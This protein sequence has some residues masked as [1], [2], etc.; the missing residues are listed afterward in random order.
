MK[1]VNSFHIASAEDV[2]GGKT[3]DIYFART[4]QILR[5]KKIDKHVV[6]EVR[7]KELPHAYPWAVFAGLEYALRMLERLNC[8]V[9]VRA[10][11]ERTVFGAGDVVF[12]IAGRYNGFCIYETPIL[13]F[14]CHASGI[15][16]AA[17]R[18][19][20]A[21]GNRALL[22]FGARRMHPSLAP[23]ID[24]N[25][26]AGGMDGVSVIASAEALGI[27]PSGTMPHALILVI[28]NTVEATRAFRTIIGPKVACVSLIDTFNDEKI[29]SLNVARALG[30]SLYAVR[31]DTPGSRRGDM[32]AI[33]KEVRWELD[34]NGFRHVKLYVSGGLDEEKILK[35]NPWADGYGVGTHIAS[36]PV[37]DFA[38]DI[39]AI[40]G[41]PVA[42]RG[43]E[44]GEKKLMRC[45]R[46]HRRITLPLRDPAPRCACGRVMR[47]IHR[48]VMRK[49]KIAAGLPPVS[50]I[51]A[52]TL[53]ELKRV[54]L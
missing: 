11:D 6:A 47:N 33:L 5:A 54:E 46:C 44:A 38:L 53:A 28:G 40:D 1:K 21:A 31:L 12:S 18:C 43:K 8:D 49:G 26:Y 25:A 22:S 10:I 23:F 36:A 9:E 16:T 13:G 52:R 48:T 51:R 17:A 34:L 41:K 42:K 30:K 19:R 32:A 35:L 14:L 29:E 37:V 15:A 39:V 7:A 2:I 3:T 27:E 24:R 50:R 20:K 4:L 45:P